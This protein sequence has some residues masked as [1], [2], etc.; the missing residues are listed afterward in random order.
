[1]ERPRPKYGR[2]DAAAR[3]GVAERSNAAVSK[4]VIRASGSEVQILSPPFYATP[5]ETA[6]FRVSE[7]H[8]RLRSRPPKTACRGRALARVWRAHTSEHSR[9]TRLRTKPADQ[10][11]DE[12]VHS[13]AVAMAS[14]MAGR[15]QNAQVAH[16]LLAV[17]DVRQVMDMEAFSRAAV[18]APSACQCERLAASRFP[19]SAAEVG[20]MLGL[21][22]RALPLLEEANGNQSDAKGPQP[23]RQVNRHRLSF[24]AH[25]LRNR[26]IRGCA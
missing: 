23:P 9:Q 26:R 15:A 14:A 5:P 12:I 16:L 7:R 25:A 2:Y 20:A 6:G 1:M 19:L 11:V 4:T 8:A 13:S 10:P 3:G 17:T 22:G 21:P 24:Q 18:L